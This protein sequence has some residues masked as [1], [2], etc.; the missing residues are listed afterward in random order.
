LFVITQQ[1]L[2]A[3]VKGIY[4][5]FLQRKMGDHVHVSR[6][7]QP[8]YCVI[9]NYVQLMRIFISKR[10]GIFFFGVW[11]KCVLVYIK[12]ISRRTRD[13]SLPNNMH[14]AARLIHLKKFIVIFISRAEKLVNDT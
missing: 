10:P 8:F 5:Q 11:H 1:N 14:D 13:V 9:M 12:G 2:V 7:T 4:C 6:S 3:D